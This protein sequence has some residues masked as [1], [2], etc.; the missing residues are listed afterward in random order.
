MHKV[1]SIRSAPPVTMPTAAQL[2]SSSRSSEH[3]VRN[4]SVCF[5]CQKPG[6]YAKLCPEPTQRHNRRDRSENEANPKSLHE[7]EA[8]LRTNGVTDGVCRALVMQPISK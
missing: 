5:N 2:P 7:S 1:E 8:Q 3:T 6:H 4:S